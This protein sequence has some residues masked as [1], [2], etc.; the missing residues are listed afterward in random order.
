MISLA[1][2]I[3]GAAATVLLAALAVYGKALT[4]GAGVVAAAFGIAIVVSVGI[5][6]LLLLVLFVGASSLATRYRFAE[7]RAR[8]VQEGAQ[9]E[10]GISNVLAHILIP[11]GLALAGGLGVGRPSLTAILYTSALAFALAD[12]FA[13]EFGVLAGSA[14]SILTFRRVTP[15]TNGG[16]SG[17][18]EAAA[19][20]AAVITAGAG[21][22]LLALFGNPTGSVPLYLAAA[23]AAGFLGCQVDSILGE[24]LENRGWLTKGSTNFLGMLA[25]VGVALALVL[26][27]RG[28]A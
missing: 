19:L 23:I 25:S 9:G 6:Y 20:G 12:T 11:T 5:P 24:R 8:H 26:A 22:G 28:P 10:R 3:I 2:S 14:R 1:T 18:G 15:G 16:V 13:S 27:L 17:R 4:P 21:W 7:K